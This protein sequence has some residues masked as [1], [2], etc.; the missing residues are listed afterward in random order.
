MTPLQSFHARALSLSLCHV[1]L[2]ARGVTK[3]LIWGPQ[4]FSRISKGTIV[5]V[6]GLR[7]P[8]TLDCGPFSTLDSVS[9]PSIWVIETIFFTVPGNNLPLGF[10]GNG[11][12]VSFDEEEEEEEEAPRGMQHVIMPRDVIFFAS[13]CV[14]PSFSFP[15]PPG[16]LTHLSLYLSDG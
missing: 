2:S 10:S 15:S 16:A 3:M 4:R 9:F 8:C 14:R 12:L 11:A 7:H 5:P 13:V 1:A 6:P